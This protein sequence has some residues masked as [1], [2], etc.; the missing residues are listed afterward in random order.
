MA[1]Y[2]IDMVA[3]A[4]GQNLKKIFKIFPYVSLLREA[5][6]K[7]CHDSIVSELIGNAM[8]LIE[9]VRYS[10]SN[11]SAWPGVGDRVCK[12]PHSSCQGKD[13]KVCY[14]HTTSPRPPSR[15]NKV[16]R[17]GMI[18]PCLQFSYVFTCYTVWDL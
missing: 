10:Q 3:T 11:L 16:F 15:F 8:G 2:F 12:L 13:L 9:T 18:T 6:T 1:A 14:T 5:T 7:K 17:D 4:A